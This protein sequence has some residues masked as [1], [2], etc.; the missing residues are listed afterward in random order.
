MCS[1]QAFLMG[2]LSH[3]QGLLQGVTLTLHTHRQAGNQA[4][5]ITS[6]PNSFKSQLSPTCLFLLP[7]SYAPKTAEALQVTAGCSSSCHSL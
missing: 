4:Q 2:R 1:C 3:V 5:G 7:H 6:S